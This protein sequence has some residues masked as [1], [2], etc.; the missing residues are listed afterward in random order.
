MTRSFVEWSLVNLAL[1]DPSWKPKAIVAI[2]ELLRVTLAEEAER[3]GSYFL[4]SYGRGFEKS[5]FIDSELAL[6]LGLRRLLG[7][8]AAQRARFQERVRRVEAR[9]AENPLPPS[10][11]DEAWTF[12]AAVAL[13]ALKASDVLDFT[14]H[15]A[16]FEA[17]LRRAK[18][19]LIDPR[20]GL[21]NSSY[22]LSGAPRDGPEGSS[23]WLAVSMLALVDRDF[24]AA[25]YQLAKRALLHS[26]G[27]F[28]LAR[29]WP[30][31][32]L[33]EHDIDSGLQVPIV[34][35]SPSSSGLALV[36]AATFDDEAA[37]GSLLASVEFAAFPVRE[38]GE[39]HY[40]AGN[41]LG[42]AVVL[43]ALTLGPA[44]QQLGAT[45]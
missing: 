11:P 9:F 2:D 28:G 36:A 15:S 41:Q 6:S 26:I 44:W 31:E 10:Y 35:A 5:L 30:H 7:D 43:Y 42:D 4:M 23:I 1:R 20:T 12:D 34:E 24:A 13:A 18:T 25:Q 14:D 29:E 32:A 22:H 38:H 37:L 19:G 3:G 16:L 27:G 45:R 40:A 33:A 8:D 39:L 21:L 17:W